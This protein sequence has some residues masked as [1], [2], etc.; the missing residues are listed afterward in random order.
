MFEQVLSEDVTHIN[1]N[2]FLLFHIRIMH[3]FLETF[4]DTLKIEDQLYKFFF[5]AHHMLV[6]TTNW[7]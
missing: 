1:F 6:S 5:I 3:A 4:L 7:S 2:G